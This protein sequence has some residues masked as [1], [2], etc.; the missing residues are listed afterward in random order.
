MS[1]LVTHGPKVKTLSYVLRGAEA[2]GVFPLLLSPPLQFI[3]WDSAELRMR[4][5][6]F[7]SLLFLQFIVFPFYFV[8]RLCFW[9]HC[10]LVFFDLPKPEPFVW[11]ESR[12]EVIIQHSELIL[13]TKIVIM[14][15]IVRDEQSSEDGEIPPSFRDSGWTVLRRDSHRCSLYHVQLSKRLF[16]CLAS[17]C[18]R[19]RDVHR[20]LQGLK[21]GS[22]PILQPRLQPKSTHILCTRRVKLN[23]GYSDMSHLSLLVFNIFQR[24][25]NQ[26]TN[27]TWLVANWWRRS[28]IWF[29]L[30]VRKMSG[31]CFRICC[32]GFLDLFC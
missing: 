26:S 27:V 12:K 3:R 29:P 11:K 31:S 7:P 16:V 14:G 19:P 18:A 30:L 21:K 22:T 23:Y 17:L 6:N 32:V 2:V 20:C 13:S 8:L 10:S 15:L 5:C 25:T 9:F 4:L 28:I 24:Q 1:W